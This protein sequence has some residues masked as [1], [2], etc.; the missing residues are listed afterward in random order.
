MTELALKWY[1]P[2]MER[3]SQL[4]KLP[5][6]IKE[7]K[8]AIEEFIKS[9]AHELAEGEINAKEINRERFSFALREAE[10]GN[11]NLMEIVSLGLAS[12]YPYDA[13]L[14]TARMAVSS[15]LRR[16]LTKSER[17]KLNLVNGIINEELRRVREE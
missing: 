12:R 6:I 2:L 9:Y 3:E 5:E 14:R 10:E 16:G 7:D 4:G 11:P 1:I 8:G 13:V 15:A 17:K